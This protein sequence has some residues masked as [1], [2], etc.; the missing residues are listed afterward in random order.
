V[1]FIYIFICFIFT[2]VNLQA[3]HDTLTIKKENF[4][5][6]LGHDGK[7]TIKTIGYTYSRPFF[8]KKRDWLRLG[9]AL[10]GAGL[11]TLIDEPVSEAFIGNKY[12]NKTFDMLANAGD[13][14]GQPE[15]NYPLMFAV[16]GA[17]VTFGND[18]LRDTGIMLFASVTTSGILQTFAKTA[19]GRARPKTGLGAHYFDPFRGEPDFHS[20]PSGHTML[21]LSTAWVMARQIKFKPLKYT[22]Y[23]IPVIV[24]LS[25]IYHRAHFPSDVLLGSALG[26]ACAESVIRIYPKY[27]K[28]LLEGK[29][30]SMLPYRNGVRLTYQF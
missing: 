17:G 4:I 20:F 18:W 12:K 3:Q 16:W 11:L 22:F 9:G 27:K 7:L 28:Q 14:M 10:A 13:F 6:R 19:V 30:L 15:N 25:R 24:G 29:G 8:W 26:I 21:A 2:T 1:K 23:T 5:Q